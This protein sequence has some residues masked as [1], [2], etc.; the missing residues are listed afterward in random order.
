MIFGKSKNFKQISKALDANQVIELL[1]RDNA[2]VDDIDKLL[3]AFD[4]FLQSNESK[5][6]SYKELKKIYNA[7]TVTPKKRK[8]K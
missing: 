3:E 7:K 1:S 2:E 4:E 8:L 5:E 6:K